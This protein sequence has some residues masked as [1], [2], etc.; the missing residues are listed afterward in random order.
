MNAEI[1]A[2]AVEML[3]ARKPGGRTAM[4]DERDNGT[5]AQRLGRAGLINV[6]AEIVGSP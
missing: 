5:L 4:R 3:V 2:R 1:G 6:V